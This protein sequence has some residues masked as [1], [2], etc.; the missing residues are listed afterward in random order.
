MSE[1]IVITG[2]G[3]VSAIGNNRQQ[4]LENLKNGFSGI[5]EV[6]YLPTVHHE[7]PVGEVKLSNSQMCDLLGIGH[8]QV[9]SRTTLMGIMAVKE[10]LAQ[11]GASDTQ[12]YMTLIS[13]TTVGGM[14]VSEQLFSQG[15]SQDDCSNCIATH[16]CGASTNAIAAYFGD[17]F[18]STITPSTACSSA[19]NAIILGSDLIKAGLAQM[20][21]AGGSESLTLFHLNGFKSLMI[22]DTEPCKP[23]DEHRKGLNLGEGAAFVVLESET[24]AISRNAHILANISGYGNACDAFHQTASSP[25]GEGAFLA[26][27]KAL[28]EAHIT[29]QDIDYINAHG[30]GTPNN[31]QS[32]SAA[33]HRLFDDK[34][35]PV[36][37]TKSFTGHTTSASGSIETVISLLA[38]QEQF[39]PVNLG[40]STPMKDGGIIPITESRKASLSNV[41]CNSFGFGGN[42]SSLILSKYTK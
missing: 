20:V 3:I 19:L 41:M 21:V 22:L 29:T 13:G 25:N 1:K 37:S 31:D 30:T 14:D 24:H 16:T 28:S 9:Y 5:S 32:E 10:A 8:S 40:W 42:D 36:S 27:S 34:V 23:F 18:N 35:P 15:M 2:S 17:T 4:C 12:N 7:F 33:I 11:A 38:M 39:L 26:M 6:R